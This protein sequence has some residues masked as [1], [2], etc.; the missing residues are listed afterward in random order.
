MFNNY[1][2]LSS[3]SEKFRRH[4]SDIAI[5]INNELNLKKTSVL[6]DIGS[7]DGIFLEP[8]KQLGLNPIGVEPAKIYQKLQIQRV[9]KL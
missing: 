4:F 7:N 8:L 1:L 9:L 6:V 5:E 3:T 2:Y